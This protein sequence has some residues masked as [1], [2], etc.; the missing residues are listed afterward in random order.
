MLKFSVGVTGVGCGV[1]GGGGGFV[2]AIHI[3]SVW[4]GSSRCGGR[5][6]VDPFQDSS[7]GRE[8]STSSVGNRL[9]RHSR[10][11]VLSGLD[12]ELRT[13][14]GGGLSVPSGEFRRSQ[15]H[16]AADDNTRQDDRDGFVGKAPRDSHSFPA[17]SDVNERGDPVD[18]RPSRN[19]HSSEARRSPSA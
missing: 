12:M 2:R 4:R 9:C 6:F 7:A 11:V 15:R 13:S 5:S 18:D 10:K 17:A 16:K 3:G 19:R 1:T 14:L 8:S